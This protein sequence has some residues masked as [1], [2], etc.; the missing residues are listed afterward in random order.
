MF[1][2]AGLIASKI[3]RNYPEYL[4]DQHDKKKKM[5]EFLEKNF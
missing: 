2:Y 4:Q 5:C 3:K 1:L